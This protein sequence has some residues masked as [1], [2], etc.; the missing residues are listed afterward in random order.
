LCTRMGFYP[1]MH[2]R[3]QSPK[4]LNVLRLL[5]TK[6]KMPK[7]FAVLQK[8]TTRM[9]VRKFIFPN[10]RLTAKLVCANKHKKVFNKKVVRSLTFTNV[11]SPIHTK[12]P[13]KTQFTE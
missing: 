8:E 7:H 9:S 13:Y 3:L 2:L 1:E 5:R 12:C 6:P 10:S 4:P 11:I